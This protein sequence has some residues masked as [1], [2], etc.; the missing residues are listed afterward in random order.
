MAAEGWQRHLSSIIETEKDVDAIVV[1][2]IP[3]NHLFDLPTTIR[4]RHGV[5]IYYFDGDLPASLPAFGGFASGFS[6]YDGADISLWDGFFS[7][8]LGALPTLESM[9]ARRC[10]AVWWALT[11]GFSDLPKQTRR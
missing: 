7:N 1:L 2:N 9:G 8:S 4:R 6:I 11:R 10:K 5:P 3:L